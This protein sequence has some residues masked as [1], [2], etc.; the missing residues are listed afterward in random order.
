MEIMWSDSAVC[1]LLESTFGAICG[2]Y[3]R[4]IVV[5][6]RSAWGWL[7]RRTWANLLLAPP[8]TVPAHQYARRTIAMCWILLVYFRYQLLVDSA[9]KCLTDAKKS[10]LLATTMKNQGF[11]LNIQ[12]RCHKLLLKILWRPIHTMY[13]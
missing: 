1:K 11:C 2:G 9:C 12:I 8:T 5:K 13:E 4:L 10:H 6:A 3:K 7:R